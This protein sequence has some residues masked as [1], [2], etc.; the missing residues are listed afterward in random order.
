MTDPAGTPTWTYCPD[1]QPPHSKTKPLQVNSVATCDDGSRSVFGTYF[2]RGQGEFNSYLMDASGT[3]LWSEPFGSGTTTQGVFWTATSQDG[4]YIAVGGQT[5]ESV[6]CLYAYA[7]A[8]GTTL[9]EVQTPARIN[10]VSLSADGQYLAAC[11]DKTVVVYQYNSTT[12][13]YDNI[14]SYTDAVYG[15]NSCMISRNGQT[16]VASGIHYPKSNSETASSSGTSGRVFSFQVEGAL[17]TP[18]GPCP[19][20]CGS[21]RVAVVASGAFWAVSLHDGSCA[22]ISQTEPTK[23]LWT[24]KPD[25]PNLSLS[26][27]VAVTQTDQGEV[28]V[29]CGTNLDNAPTG[30][31]LYLVKSER[32]DL[33]VEYSGVKYKPVL[34]WTNDIDFGV[35]PGVSMDQNAQYVSAI[36]GKPKGQ[37]IHESAGNFYL[38]SGPSG[39]LIWKHHTPMM[40]WGMQIAY[41]GSA[42]IGGSDDGTV[43]YW[44]LG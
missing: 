14:Y 5:S 28:F 19:L 8:D 18:T 29:A 31:F 38:F 37:T 7:G 24:Y 34:Q 13:Q 26:Y 25:N 42:V 32:L 22:L 43:Y 16:V 3:P 10:Q 6:G 30:G 2:E 4:S 12:Q 23:T 33:A 1:P 11:Y 40:N 20:T 17:V 39:D 35:N 36:D 41:D 15:F 27:A 21:M 44:D 9:L